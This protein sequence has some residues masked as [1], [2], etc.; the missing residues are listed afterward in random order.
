MRQKQSST[1]K[2]TKRCAC[3]CG[4]F[5]KQNLVDKNPKAE[6]I[7]KHHPNSKKNR[8]GAHGLGRNRRKFQEVT[9]ASI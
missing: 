2:S 8:Y 7:Y 9:N 5:L 3:G 6:F 4:K 1:V